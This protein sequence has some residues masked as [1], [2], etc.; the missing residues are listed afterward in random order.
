MRPLNTSR[1]SLALLRAAHPEPGLA[2]TLVATLLALATGRSAPGVL[3]VAATVLATQAAIGWANDAIDA[4]R[5][6]AVGRADKPVAS[7]EVPRRVAAWC[8]VAAAVL[9]VP[10]G[11]LSGPIA[12][13]VIT[14]ALV[15]ALLYDWP[16]KSTPISV[17]PYAVSFGA[18]PTFVVLGLPGAPWPP[19]WLAAAGALLGSGAHFANVLPDLAQDARTGVRGL[20]HLL[21]ER[22]STVAAGALLLAAT[23][24]LAFGPAGPPS[25]VGYAALLL[26]VVVLPASAYLAKRRPGSDAAFRGAIAIALVDVALLLAGGRIR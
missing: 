6:A 26:A 25:T 15:S 2:V 16:L 8:A 12:A 13:A 4:G 20:P 5:D 14:L 10:L 24:V 22:G 19:W 18:L 9:V 21:G 7:G 1:R 23:C 17:L 11:L 3:A